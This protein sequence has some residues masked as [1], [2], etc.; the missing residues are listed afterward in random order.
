[1]AGFGPGDVII[2]KALLSGSGGNV[3]ITSKI[4][5]ISAYEDIT[6]PYTSV[7]VEVRDT[8]DIL[9]WNV[10]LDGE[11]KLTISFGQ[12][13][14]DPW[15]GNQMIVTSVE[16]TKT[17]ENPRI[18]IYNLSAYSSHMNKFPKVEKSFKYKQGPNIVQ[19]L[20]NEFLK[21][22][23]PVK[24]GD[25]GRGI[26]GNEKIPFV[27]PGIS[28]HKAI[29][30]TLLN[31]AAASHLSSAWVVF[32]NNKN[33][34]VDH[35]EQLL[36]KAKGSPVA[37]Y[38]QRPT[39]VNWIKDMTLQNFIILAIRENARVDATSSMLNDK[40]AA[41]PLDVFSNFFQRTNIGGGLPES[42]LNILYNSMAPPSHMKDVIP[43][44]KKFVANIEGQ[45]ITI[46]VALNPALTVG[47]GVGVQT[48][49]PMGDTNISRPDK[50]SGNHM[51][52]ETC[53]T[54]RVTQKR[55][56]GIST[57]LAVKGDLNQS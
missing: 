29:R 52:I 41:Q 14:Q 50:I 17:T 55:M 27:L 4:E 13:G 5:T 10:G 3:D 6:K 56:Q 22:N 19:D 46:Q 21:P 45:S 20:I 43:A 51:I 54:V 33:L 28:I 23:K 47:A 32:E 26:L 2:H 42:F 15:T 35:L 49:S 37:T 8:N 40:V 7:V 31:S 39:G 44:R 36:T 18:A 34:V 48:L 9:N 30:T 38:Y 16:K 25:Q 1:M 12:P 57:I 24:I 53:H 11:N